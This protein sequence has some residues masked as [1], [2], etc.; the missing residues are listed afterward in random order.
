LAGNL[1]LEVTQYLKDLYSLG[2]LAYPGNDDDDDDDGGGEDSEVTL[3]INQG[4]G[5]FGDPCRRI[6]RHRHTT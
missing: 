5:I 6:D 2:G 3:A 4:R 1:K